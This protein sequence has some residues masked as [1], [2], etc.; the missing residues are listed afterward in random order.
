VKQLVYVVIVLSA[1]AAAY[2]ESCHWENASST[3]NPSCD[4]G[5]LVG[6]PISMVGTCACETSGSYTFKFDDECYGGYRI[7][8]EGEETIGGIVPLGAGASIPIDP[9]A[10]PFSCILGGAGYS[11]EVDVTCY[12]GSTPHACDNLVSLSGICHTGCEP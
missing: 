4:C 12:C 6:G 9:Q 7:A 1:V 8:E 10:D 3:V 2:A 11:F 5:V